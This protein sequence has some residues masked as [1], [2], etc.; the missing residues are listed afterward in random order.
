M[1]VKRAQ[2]G[3]LLRLIV[4]GSE[5][6]IITAVKMLSFISLR[7]GV[8]EFHPHISWSCI[9]FIS[10]HHH[11]ISLTRRATLSFEP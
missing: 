6:V 1:V 7:A 2:P 11:L 9:N 5:L 10:L 8:Y 4:F 3:Y